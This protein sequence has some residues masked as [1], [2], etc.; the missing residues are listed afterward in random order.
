MKSLLRI[1]LPLAIMAMVICV[2][3]ARGQNVIANLPESDGVV[4]VNM[5]RI[6]N[7]TLPRVLSAEQMS[8]VQAALAK[9]KQVAGFDVANIET[10]VVGLRLNRGKLFKLR[11]PLLSVE[12]GQVN[13]PNVSDKSSAGNG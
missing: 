5:R 8:Q 6:V 13:A 7:E 3:A 4:A 9:A 1:R 12:E 2:T 11:L 10:A